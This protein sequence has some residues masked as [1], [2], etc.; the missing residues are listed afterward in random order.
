MFS[1][2]MQLVKDSHILGEMGLSMV[3]LM[4]NMHYP[5]LILVPKKQDISEIAELSVNERATLI[6]E[7]ADISDVMKRIYWPDKLNVAALGNQVSQLHVHIIARFKT[8]DVWPE[9]VWGKQS[10][11]YSKIALNEAKEILLRE[12]KKIKD[13]SI[14]QNT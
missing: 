10:K 3:L 1:V 6:E 14:Y 5:W 2:D 4:D 11:R 7:I 12:L 13:F 8:D 9:P